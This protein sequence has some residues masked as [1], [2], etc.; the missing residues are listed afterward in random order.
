MRR[1]GGGHLHLFAYGREGAP[2]LQEYANAK[3]G[4][5]VLQ[6]VTWD[7]FCS[8]PMPTIPMGSQLEFRV[9]FCPVRRTRQTS[10][11]RADKPAGSIREVDA[12][13]L[14]P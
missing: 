13:S 4:P 1:A 10:P 7:Y 12:S 8:K 9:R 2:L 6:V 14:A 11:K 5:L 3:A